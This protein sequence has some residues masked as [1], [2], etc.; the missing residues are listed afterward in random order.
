[1]SPTLKHHSIRA[2]AL[3]HTNS[4]P[5]NSEWL[6]P[7]DR[8]SL[9]LLAALAPRPFHP[10]PALPLEA[11]GKSLTCHYLGKIKAFHGNPTRWGSNHNTPR[12]RKQVLPST[13]HRCIEGTFTIHLCRGKTRVPSWLG[14]GR[15]RSCY[16][17]FRLCKTGHLLDGVMKRWHRLPGWSLDMARN[18][19][20]KDVQNNTANLAQTRACALGFDTA[21]LTGFSCDV[22]VLQKYSGRTTDEVRN[23]QDILE[24]Y[25]KSTV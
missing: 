7:S 21:V 10:W 14:R 3:F 9:A 2:C 23:F 11:P 1:M 6:L 16:T 19:C 13:S 20:L 22:E 12:Q 25:L 18:A 24:T 15:R 8:M 17:S 4:N 5:L